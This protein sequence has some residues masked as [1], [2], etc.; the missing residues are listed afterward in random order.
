M[1]ALAGLPQNVALS[2]R[3]QQESAMTT[4]VLAFPVL[5]S[6]DPAARAARLQ[7][8]VDALIDRVDPS[9]GARLVVGDSAP[10]RRVL[11]E[12]TQA[13]PTNATVLLLGE[14]GTGKEVVARFV[15]RA[16]ARSRGPFVAINCAALPEHLLESELFGHE[17]GAFTGAVSP[18]PGQLELAASG[19]L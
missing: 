2:G 13:A 17:R 7:A 4:E 5:H 1:C 15:H 11:T 10:W 3:R 18:K 16:S 8:R 12:A 6:D 19:V 14:S 9:T